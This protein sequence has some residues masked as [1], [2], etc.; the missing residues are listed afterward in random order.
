MKREVTARV[1][2]E[3]EKN[4]RGF[5]YSRELQHPIVI[6]ENPFSKGYS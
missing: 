4:K 3:G 6:V 5:C 1:R 2:G